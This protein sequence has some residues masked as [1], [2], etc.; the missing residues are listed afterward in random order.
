MARRL[1]LEGV[2]KATVTV[3]GT[4]RMMLPLAAHNRQK[5]HLASDPRV[6][7]VI[8]SLDSSQPETIRCIRHPPSSQ[9]LLDLI[10]T[11]YGVVGISRR[12][13]SRSIT[14]FVEYSLSLHFD[15]L[16]DR[17]TGKSELTLLSQ[18]SIRGGIVTC[19]SVI[20]KR[21]PNPSVTG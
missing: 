7:R 1:Q 4:N 17:V 14:M 20:Y 9:S 3:L 11:G 13:F 16:N 10:G 12:A 21:P 6:Q 15:T 5:S 18:S 8:D 2:R 19:G